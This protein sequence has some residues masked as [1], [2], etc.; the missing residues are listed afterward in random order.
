MDSNFIGKNYKGIIDIGADYE[1]GN[2]NIINLGVSLN[3]GILESNS[4][5]ASG[6]KE[7][8]VTTY[9]IQPRLFGEL[10]LESISRFHPSVG[11]GY[12][13]MVFD[14]YVVDNGFNISDE[15]DTQS[16]FNL[17]LGFSYDVTDKIF[18]QT[19]YDFIKLIEKDVPN[20]KFNTNVNIV[21]IGA[22]Y[23]L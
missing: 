17:N 7:F 2:L 9:V 18:V 15:I 22:G 16:G 12:T 4:K 6:F 3:S 11:L 19:Q 5:Q 8:K 21:K 1:I 13:F 20:I 23:R 10:D 14:A